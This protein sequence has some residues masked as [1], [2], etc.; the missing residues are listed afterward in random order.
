MIHLA[1]LLLALQRVLGEYAAN[2]DQ[3]TPGLM[4]RPMLVA[5]GLV[6]GL[7]LLVWRRTGRPRL[8][9]LVAAAAA[10]ALWTPHPARWLLGG[11][12]RLGLY[13]P[14]ASFLVLGA[15]GLGLL[16]LGRAAW[17]S[18][19]S[20]PALERWG[21]FVG[22]L[23]L[24]L[25]LLPLPALLRGVGLA[26]GPA[27]SMPAVALP[28][29]PEPRP[30]LYLVV[31]DAYTR[32]DILRERLGF[33][34]GPFLHE[35]TRRGFSV[36]PRAR[37]NYPWT[38]L[39]MAS[40][41]NLDYLTPP[42]AHVRERPRDQSRAIRLV[43]DPL[44]RRLLADAGYRTRLVSSGTTAFYGPYDEHVEAG[45]TDFEAHLFQVSVLEDLLPEL[46]LAARRRQLVGALE[47]LAPP[48]P[49]APPTFTLAHVMAPHRPF[50]FEA[51]GSPGESLPIAGFPDNGPAIDSVMGAGWYRRRYT[52]QVA[53]VNRGVLAALDRIRARPDREAVV[54]LMGD[55]G[56]RCF[57][58]ASTPGARLEETFAIL[59]AVR[60]P[61]A[62]NLEL[63]A[64]ASP[65]TALRAVVGGLFGRALPVLPDRSF[66]AMP[67]APLALTELPRVP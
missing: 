24:L 33:D 10:L 27:F 14:V 18:G 44:L 61:E 23:G 45:W 20:S 55:H 66:T 64:G 19:E 7:Q 9:A 51:D 2:A 12:D 32:G 60:V 37:A 48:P 30:D 25:A 22:A 39:A 1:P 67:R 34:N 11:L 59:L 41:L 35:L 47:A 57:E 31:L 54:V 36:A 40:A 58:G 46:R 29:R 49:G 28:P 3:L 63:A 13:G 4:L 42:P 52:A 15:L 16:G 5:G 43:E 50:V 53:W 65:V 6:V 38:V 8:A 26:L 17:N 21:R 62:W 56:S